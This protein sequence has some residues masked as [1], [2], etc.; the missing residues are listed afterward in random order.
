[1]LYLYEYKGLVRKIILNYKFNS[2]AYYC[3][4][5]AKML[6]N[7][8]NVYRFFSFYDI[9]IPV[10]MENSKKLIRG[11]NQTEL[12]TDIL[13]KKLSITNG[14]NYISKIR[15]TKVQS[16]LDYNGRK[17]NIKNAFLVN[18][19]NELYGKKVIIFDDICTTGSTVNE[20]AKILKNAGV[21]NILVIVLAKD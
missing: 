4:F 1:M 10:P 14:K 6:L 15:N 20:I 11:Y 3:N 2:K 19:K 16:T 13:C 8:K 12:I 9:I 7:C 18:N 5:F 21:N 17:E